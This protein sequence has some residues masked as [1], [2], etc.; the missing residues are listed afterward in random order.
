LEISLRVERAAIK[1]HQM[2]LDQDALVG[3]TT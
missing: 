1:G 3:V 2:V